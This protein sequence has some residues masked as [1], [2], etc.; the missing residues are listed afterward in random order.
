MAQRPGWGQVAAAAAGAALLALA[1]VACA[2]GT[3]GPLA[4]ATV[5]VTLVASFLGHRRAAYAAVACS[6][7]GAAALGLR[8]KID[9]AVYLD[10][11][12]QI[13]FWAPFVLAAFCGLVLA[14]LAGERP[15]GRNPLR[16]QTAVL[17]ALA[18]VT[19][20]AAPSLIHSGIQFALLALNVMLFVLVLGAIRDESAHRRMM[21]TW[22]VWGVVQCLVAFALYFFEPRAFVE[23]FPL[24][25]RLFLDLNVTSGPRL[26]GIS[27]LRRGSAFFGHNG[28]A[29]IMNLVFPVALG[30]LLRERARARRLFLVGVLVLVLATNLLTMSRAGLGSLVIM[31]AFLSLALRPLRRRVA[32]LGIGLVVAVVAVTWVENAALNGLFTRAASEARLFRIA[33]SSDQSLVTAKE[34]V[35]KWS[36]AFERLGQSFPLGDGVGNFKYHTRAST[37]PHAHSIYFSF[38]FD[39]GLAGLLVLVSIAAVV[40]RRFV[41]HLGRQE[42]YLD[43]MAVVFFGGFLALAVHGLVD[44][45]YNVPVLWAYL[46]MAFA[47]LNLRD[48]AAAWPPHAV[49]APE[50]L[51]CRS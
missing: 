43:T 7:V 28:T 16:A 31:V 6:T 48:A 50:A 51:R 10:Y 20:L 15:P 17:L 4:V 29:L 8:F 23:E 14:R 44:F 25:D 26:R 21:W 34:R 40:L 39:F 12:D 2:V 41:P 19:L 32:V 3:W 13:P 18:A 9:P 11:Y 36:A 33:T 24:F 42:T 38:L 22:V 35:S 47:T 37:F 30:L 49:P 27:A 46:G 1:A 5:A 45:E